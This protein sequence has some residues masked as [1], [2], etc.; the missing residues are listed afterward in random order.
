MPALNLPVLSCSLDPTSRS[1]DLAL[2]SSEL[3]RKQGHQSRMVD[4]VDYEL[5]AFDNDQV[6][7]STTFA[8]LHDIIR[9]A[10][11]IVL[12]FPVYNWAPAATVKSLIEA[13][14]ATGENGRVAA[15]FDKVVTFVCAAGL[16]HSYMATAA[17]GHSLMLDFK[18][19]INPYTA[20]I[21]ERD[22][23]GPDVLETGRADHLA[24][25][26]SVHAEISELLADRT[27]S[28]D[29]EI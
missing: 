3:L 22:W 20:Y 11:G 18:C 6:F 5:P 21:S 26:M 15:W 16:P 2:A 4:L 12:A 10:D 13:T 24:K 14:G 29:W 8:E 17:L 1:R 19:V 28:S 23:K 7:E 27:Y 25:T 9:R